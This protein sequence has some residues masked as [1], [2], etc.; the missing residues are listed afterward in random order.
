MPCGICM[1]P[2]VKP[3]IIS[4]SMFS[5]QLYEPN[6]VI[7]GTID[8]IQDCQ[9]LDLMLFTMLCITTKRT[10]YSYWY[11]YNIH[12]RIY[13]CQAILKQQYIIF[14]ITYMISLVFHND[15]F[16]SMLHV[17]REVS[18]DVSAVTHYASPCLQQSLNIIHKKY[19]CL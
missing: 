10:I 19:I 7:A 4:G 3:E 14:V 1:I 8:I 13:I 2:T 12:C 6:Q 15:N 11:I 17:H 9:F 16:D 18:P 5:F